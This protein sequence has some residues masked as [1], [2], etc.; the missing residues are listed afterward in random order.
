MSKIASFDAM[1]SFFTGCTM[2]MNVNLTPQLEGAAD[3]IADISVIQPRPSDVG[4]GP[5]RS[6]KPQN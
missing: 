1:R 4:N 6:F 3:D 2:G 5:K